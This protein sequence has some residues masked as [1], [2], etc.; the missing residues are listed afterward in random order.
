MISPLS[1]RSF[2]SKI[3]RTAVAATVTAA[4]PLSARSAPPHGDFFGRIY[5]A[6]KVTM[7]TGGQPLLEKFRMAKEVGADDFLVKQNNLLSLLNR[8]KYHLSRRARS[9]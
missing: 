6:V 2:C 8:V 7:I 9:L 1:R 5:K 4:A 3:A